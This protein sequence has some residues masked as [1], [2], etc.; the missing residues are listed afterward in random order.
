MF[1]DN[2]DEG[3]FMDIVCG[4]EA[5][6][7]FCSEEPCRASLGQGDMDIQDICARA[8]QSDVGEAAEKVEA[9]KA[10]TK[11]RVQSTAVISG[12]SRADFFA[13]TAGSK[14]P[15]DLFKEG[16]ANTI[17]N[18]ETSDVIIT[19]VS[20]VYTGTDRARKL[21]DTILEGTDRARKLQAGMLEID[22]VVIVESA[23]DVHSVK[24]EMKQKSSDL[25]TSVAATFKESAGLTVT[26]EHMETSDKTLEVKQAADIEADLEDAEQKLSEAEEKESELDSLGSMQ[27]SSTVDGNTISISSSITWSFPIVTLMLGICLLQNW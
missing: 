5:C 21:R 15:A 3:D 9:I 11:P 22:F 17:E 25:A 12:V 10:Q 16:V 2:M 24:D 14:S 23:E 19:D 27:E 4:N 6:R 7:A 18:V 13:T 26:V 1:T 20:T 8:A